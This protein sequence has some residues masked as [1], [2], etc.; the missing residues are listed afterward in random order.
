MSEFLPGEKIINI[1][2]SKD[3]CSV[4]QI[5]K[6]EIQTN[7]IFLGNVNFKQ[8]EIQTNQIVLGECKFES[9][10]FFKDLKY[11]SLCYLDKVF[12]QYLF[13]ELY[14]TLIKWIIRLFID[15][16]S[17]YQKVVK[18]FICT[19]ALF[20]YSEKKL[21]YLKL[22][23]LFKQN[24]NLEIIFF[25]KTEILS[26]NEENVLLL[27]VYIKENYVE[28]V[29]AEAGDGVTE[30]LSSR[31]VHLKDN[32]IESI[33]NK[34][35]LIGTFNSII[36]E[37]LVNTD[38]GIDYVYINNDNNLIFTDIKNIFQNWFSSFIGISP[39]FIFSNTTHK[40]NKYCMEMD[41]LLLG[42]TYKDYL[43]QSFTSYGEFAS[44]I[45]LISKNTTIPTINKI[46]IKL[47]EESA[48]LKIIEN[49]SII[50]GLDLSSF[51]ND[52]ISSENIKSIPIYK[53]K[54]ILRIEKKIFLLESFKF[55]KD[56]IKS[57]SNLLKDN[58]FNYENDIQGKLIFL[59]LEINK[60]SF[61]K[62]LINF[63]NYKK[64]NI[65]VEQ[66][67]EITTIK[68]IPIQ[69]GKKT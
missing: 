63:E 36:E 25:T 54:T 26:I 33:E 8:D 30:I 31:I 69:V 19:P 59:S 12:N 52:L 60:N 64:S 15:S 65:L 23:K 14:E 29:S 21:L 47:I 5:S 16:L 42:N 9:D 4:Y 38:K 3:G 44:Q 13:N 50:K 17:D 22:K 53:L 45:S 1:D 67:R 49:Y 27:S 24:I 37:T 40:L 51:K 46:P 2:I 56:K 43:A 61:Y 7:Q 68:N 32:D 28:I 18:V 34:F 35:T 41:W 62:I 58:D 10:I 39:K 20:Q 6:D 11:K 66:L 55:S 48:E 57:I